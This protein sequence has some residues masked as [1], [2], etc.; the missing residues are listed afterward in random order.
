MDTRT[1]RQTEILP[2]LLVGAKNIGPDANIK[3]GLQQPPSKLFLGSKWLKIT[4]QVQVQSRS[5]QD[6]VQIMS[7]SD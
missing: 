4:A 7:R 5:S 6:H 3:F 1:D 2:E